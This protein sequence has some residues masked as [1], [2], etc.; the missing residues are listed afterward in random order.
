MKLSSC[1]LILPALCSG[2]AVSANSPSKGSGTVVYSAVNAEGSRQLW[3]RADVS[4]PKYPVE[5]A[6]NGWVG[7]GVFKVS[8]DAEGKTGD[9]NVLSAI[10][11][12]HQIRPAVKVIK[13]W[14]WTAADGQTA[15]PAQ[16]LVRLDFCMANAAP[17]QV[18]A[19]CEVQAKYPCQ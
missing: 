6:K 10:P 13:G 11:V 15:Q 1:L 17:E 16:Q 5:M 8:I 9:V 3:S 12:N 14:R 19:A 7:C 2:L 18:Q 4:P